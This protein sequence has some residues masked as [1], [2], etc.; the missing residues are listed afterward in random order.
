[1]SLSHFAVL[2]T[3]VVTPS[4]RRQLYTKF[5]EDNVESWQ[6]VLELYDLV[7]SSESTSQTVAQRAQSFDKMRKQLMN[8]VSTQISSKKI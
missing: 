1:M 8:L 5:K 3:S 2:T 7:E 6:E 4:I